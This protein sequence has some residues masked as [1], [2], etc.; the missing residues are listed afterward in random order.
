MG[1]K[2][3]TFSS[4]RAFEAFAR[5]GTLSGAAEELCISSSA[6]SHQ[7]KSLEAFVGIKLFTRRSSGLR[8]T[9]AG[10]R[11]LVGVS[12]ALERIE[13]ETAQLTQDGDHNLIVINTYQTLAQFWLMPL[14]PDFLSHHPKASIRLVTDPGELD[15]GGADIDLA[16][17]H[18]TSP[19]SAY[20]CAKLF[21]ERAR[22]VASPDYIARHAAIT[23][24][25]DLAAH[26]LIECTWEEAEWANWLTTL[27]PNHEPP[28]YRL[29]CDQRS[30]AL[31]AAA[32]GIGIALDR[33]PNGEAQITLGNLQPIAALSAPT[34]AAY[35][36]IGPE[37]SA[38][39]SV[40]AKFAR[41][42]ED[43]AADFSASQNSATDPLKH[44]GR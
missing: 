22:A 23:S 39:A 31:A 18:A 26:S 40:V 42:L 35:Y 15:L 5:H 3:P 7:I 14:L 24:A 29:M 38:K 19:P 33:Y 4:L 25:A 36:L 37:R 32:A 8:I 27:D 41:W 6:I 20:Y 16:I 10:K 21:D 12:E 44:S 1:R 13:V 34:G 17:R 28:R 43:M 9:P 30:H 11:Y 2:L